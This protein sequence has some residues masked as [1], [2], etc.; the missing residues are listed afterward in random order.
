MMN[1]EARKTIGE[2]VGKFMMRDLEEDEVPIRRFL[3]VC[4]RLDIRK[5]LMWGIL[6]QDE[7]G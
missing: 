4:V 3:R 6:V 1:K 5:P 2:A 7:E